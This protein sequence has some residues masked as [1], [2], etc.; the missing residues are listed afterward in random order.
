[1][2]RDNDVVT[3]ERYVTEFEAAMVKGILETNGVKAEVTKDYFAELINLAATPAPYAV[4]VLRRDLELARQ[5]IDST[6]ITTDETPTD[7]DN[8]D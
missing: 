8:E 3:F 5:I 2:E 1:M 4:V 6:P 7:D